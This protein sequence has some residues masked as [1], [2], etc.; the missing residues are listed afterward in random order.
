MGISHENG[1]WKNN[2][3]VRQDMSTVL[4]HIESF[5]P[6]NNEILFPDPGML[7]IGKDLVA[8]PVDH[9]ITLHPEGREDIRISLKNNKQW[10]E[11]FKLIKK[12]D[13][14]GGIHLRSNAAQA[15]IDIEGW[16]FAQNEDGGDNYDEIIVTLTNQ[17]SDE[18][19][20]EAHKEF[21]LGNP[22]C[23][24]TPLQGDELQTFAADT[25]CARRKRSHPNGIIS[26]R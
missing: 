21:K 17:S 6:P 2:R 14:K 22:F 7:F 13:M 3:R 4:K 23:Y 8:D 10:A 18:A 9:E 24:Q 19:F 15:Q 26:G 11:M 12:G 1:R 25:V 16:K 20:I 5:V